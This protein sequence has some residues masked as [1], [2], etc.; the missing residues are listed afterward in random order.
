VGELKTKP[1]QRDIALL[2]ER[3]ISPDVIVCRGEYE[4]PTK[5]KEK[6]S[7]FCDV[8]TK[9]IISGQDVQSI[10]EIPLVYKQQGMIDLLCE[11]LKISVSTDLSEWEKLVHNIQS[12]KR[13]ITIAVCG[14]Y[15]ELRDSYASII[16]AMTHAGA[17]CE[18]KVEL[19]WIETT[20]IET[21][22]G[23]LL[24]GVDGVLVPGGFGLRGVEGKISIIKHARE[25]NIPF[26]GICYGLQLAVV[27]FARHV[28]NLTAAN[29]TEVDEQTQHPVI[30]FLPEQRAIE[31]KGGT[32]RLGACKAVLKTGSVVH[33]TWPGS[34]RIMPRTYA[35]AR[36]Q[37]KQ[38]RSPCTQT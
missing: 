30:D 37:S 27:E 23:E 14:K 9:Q 19:K 1:A 34:Q 21:P 13:N 15:T 25:N 32:M 5:L 36:A 7:L 38:V 24:R 8:D 3:G 4:L 22:V 20:T 6:L 17:H 2:K 12:P 35:Q 29:T 28:C 33:G 11:K 10:Y 26:L 31:A 18:T 16:E